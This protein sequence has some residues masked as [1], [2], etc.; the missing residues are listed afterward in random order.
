MKKIRIRSKKRLVLVLV[1][2][3]TLFL[4]LIVRTC[5][6]QLIKGEWLSTKASEQQT[7]EIPVESKRGTIYDR[8]D[9]S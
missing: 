9:G 1:C 6:L 3:C 4:V 5:Y 7:R 8:G 2:A